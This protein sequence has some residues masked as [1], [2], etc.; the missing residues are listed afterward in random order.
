MRNLSFLSSVNNSV[1]YPMARIV[2]WAVNFRMIGPMLGDE[3]VSALASSAPEV[4]L[5]KGVLVQARRDLRRFRGARGAVGREIYVDAHS[6]LVSD[7][8]RWPYSFL[9]VCEVLGLSPATLRKELLNDVERNWSSHS[10]Q[11]A[12]RIATSVRGSFANVFGGRRG[13]AHSRHSTR[14]AVVH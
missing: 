5:A 1:L 4:A 12:H 14:P 9:N 11:I 10:R 2:C 6:W 8:V 7:D 3:A 13:L